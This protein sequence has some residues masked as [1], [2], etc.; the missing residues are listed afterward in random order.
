MIDKTY[1]LEAISMVL[2]EH[3]EIPDDIKQSLMSEMLG[4]VLDTFKNALN[5]KSEV[6]DETKRDVMSEIN[7]NILAGRGRRIV[8]AEVIADYPEIRFGR[9]I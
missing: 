5:D 8:V 4:S 7:M 2:N 1:S 9:Q 3:P 6:S